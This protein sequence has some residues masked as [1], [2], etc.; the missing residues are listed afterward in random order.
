M[1]SLS[2]AETLN[3]LASDPQVHSNLQGRL[4]LLK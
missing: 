4:N 1:A 2:G 3:A